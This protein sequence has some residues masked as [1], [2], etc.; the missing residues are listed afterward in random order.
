[1]KFKKITFESNK[2]VKEDKLKSFK[3]EYELIS[4]SVDNLVFDTDNDSLRRLDILKN[5]TEDIHFKDHNNDTVIISPSDF[6][7]YVDR[8]K[9]KLSNRYTKINT[10]YNNIKINGTITLNQ[11]QSAFE[12]LDI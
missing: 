5:S 1:M 11:A 7:N 8:L 6:N 3:T 2:L 9:I 12:S 4:A 10:L